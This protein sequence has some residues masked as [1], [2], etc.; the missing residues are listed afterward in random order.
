MT[1]KDTI[2]PPLASSDVDAA[3]LNKMPGKAHARSFVVERSY[4]KAFIQQP[5]QTV[6][7]FLVA[8]VR[9]CCEQQH[10]PLTI[11]GK[12]LQELKA[13]LAPVLCPDTGMSL[14]HNHK[15]RTH[16][17]EALPPAQRQSR[18]MR[19][20]IRMDDAGGDRRSGVA[21]L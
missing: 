8:A 16:P 4:A 9:G 13:L 7:S 5:E 1:R 12:P 14:I 2:L 11:L 3:T 17:S 21:R 20:S 18:W 6:E 15:A 10:V 19:A